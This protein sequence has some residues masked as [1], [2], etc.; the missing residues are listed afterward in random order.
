M[1]LYL[2][3]QITFVCTYRTVRTA[4]NKF[5]WW[6]TM[7]LINPDLAA[8]C[9]QSGCGK[10]NLRLSLSNPRDESERS[11]NLPIDVDNLRL[12]FGE[13]KTWMVFFSHTESLN[14]SVG[15]SIAG[16]DMTYNFPRICDQTAS[17]FISAPKEQNTDTLFLQVSIMH[18]PCSLGFLLCQYGNTTTARYRCL[19]AYSRIF[20]TEL[21]CRVCTVF[22]HA[23][24]L[25]QT[26]YKHRN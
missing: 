18:G 25:E 24:K 21:F 20:F 13:E 2:F 14:S 9:F 6:L 5:D 1:Q 4:G 12:K 16:V 26:N 22:V 10:P 8:D 17:V 11:M 7:E 15:A 23:E 3:L 19:S